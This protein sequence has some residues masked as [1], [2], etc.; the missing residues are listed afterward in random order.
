MAETVIIRFRGEDDVTPVANKVSDSVENVADS[1]KKA[2][3]GFS[4]LKEIGIG[5]LR[6]IG[7]LA[8]DVGKNVH[9]LHLA[10]YDTLPI[11]KHWCGSL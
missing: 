1:A 11:H 4:T 8:L 9:N 5:A 7:E 3:S 6:G 10:T 2:G